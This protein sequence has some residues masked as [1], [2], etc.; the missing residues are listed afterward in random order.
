MDAGYGR[1][2]FRQPDY[3]AELSRT[4][5]HFHEERYD[6]GAFVI[7]AS[8][9]HLL[10][11]PLDSCELE[12][13]VGSI[14]SITSRYINTREKTDGNLWQQESYDRIVRDEEHLHR[15]VQYI[16]ANPRRANVA[17]DQWHRWID[18][19]WK[20]AGWDFVDDE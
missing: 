9:C 14:K 18:P 10:M 8:H 11:R 13:E 1:C 20:A 4:I 3:S 12:D 17:R 7:M 6:V 19:E 15:V 2:W 5:L 16:G